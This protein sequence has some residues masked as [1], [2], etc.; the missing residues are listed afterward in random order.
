MGK[1]AKAT[2]KQ[3]GGD[4]YKQLEIEPVEYCER[5]GL[6]GLESSVVKYVTRHGFKNGEEDIDKAIHCL[7]LLKQF[8]YPEA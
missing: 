4:H 2:D 7:E 3:V 5:N 8:H 1:K 6:T